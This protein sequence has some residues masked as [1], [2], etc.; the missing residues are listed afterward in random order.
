MLDLQV[1][2][3]PWILNGL[4]DTTYLPLPKDQHVA[5]INCRGHSPSQFEMLKALVIH[6]LDCD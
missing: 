3:C 4:S 2:P 6:I 1:F 5:S